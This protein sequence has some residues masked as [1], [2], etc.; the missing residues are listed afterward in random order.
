[1]SKP[2]ASENHS[3]PPHSGQNS[4]TFVLASQRP[5]HEALAER[6]RK[7]TGQDVVLIQRRE[8]LTVELLGKLKPRFVFF[9][10]WSHI[11][12]EDVYT[13]YEC[14]IFHMTDVP[15]GRGGS[16]L[17]NLIARGIYHTKLSAL[18]CVQGLDAG[19][20]YLKKDLSL[21]GAAEEIFLRASRIVEEMILE[22]LETQP[23]PQPQT[24]EPTLFK[25]RKPEEGNL[26][27]LE[28]LD[29]VF[30]YIRMLDAE[31]YPPAFLEV[32][33][34]RL[35]FSRASRKQG[36]VVADVKITERKD[37]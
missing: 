16:P 9:P 35:E 3:V 14:V 8:D 24:G 26:E 6:L 36:S 30:D 1:M 37:G 31:G 17:Q 11:I 25:R 20:V 4:E 21:Y 28:S 29:K 12:P 33:A 22:I 27:N 34:F 23:E 19:P 13:R 18:R 10:H 15:F 2:E 5:W 7:R 32:G